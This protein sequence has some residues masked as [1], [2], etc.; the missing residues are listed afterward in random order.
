M[1][2]ST[3]DVDTKRLMLHLMSLSAQPTDVA[4]AAV[5]SSTITPL[6]TID[7]DTA[8]PPLPSGMAENIY[9]MQTS[10]QS[11]LVKVELIS[12]KNNAWSCS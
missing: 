7:D 11:R 4:T 6:H 1:P 8:G 2:S 10:L 12:Q 3:D 5:T 9:Q